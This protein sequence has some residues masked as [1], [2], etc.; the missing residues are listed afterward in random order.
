MDLSNGIKLQL[1][2]HTASSCIKKNLSLKYD[3]T[4]CNIIE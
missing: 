1:R 4:F 3:T 2:L